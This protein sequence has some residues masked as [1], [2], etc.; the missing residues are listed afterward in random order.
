M[1]ALQFLASFFLDSSCLFVWIPP[2][3]KVTWITPMC[4]KGAGAKTDLKGFLKKEFKGK[5]WIPHKKAA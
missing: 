5:K 1:V 2:K 3:V 4:A